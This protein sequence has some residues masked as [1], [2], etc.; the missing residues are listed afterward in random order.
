M[1]DCSKRPLIKILS[2]KIC[3]EGTL[4]FADFM[5]I[6]LYNKEHGYYG[7]DRV[8]IG[9]Q[10]DF[11]TNVSVGK[12]YG[13]TLTYCFKELWVKMEKP[14]KF[15]IVEQGAHN[16]RLADDILQTLATKELSDFKSCVEYLIIEPLPTQRAL[17][18]NYLKNFSNISWIEH[19]EHLPFFEGV[20]F[21]N[22]LLDAFPV[23]ILTWDGLTWLEK[24]V[25]LVDEKFSWINEPITDPALLKA[26]SSLPK[27]LSKNF[28]LE[29]SLGTQPWLKSIAKK[30]SRGAILI[31][32]YGT[33]GIE[34]FSPHRR[35]GTIAC[36]KNHRRFD[37]PLE[38][39]GERDITAQVDF[40]KATE[41]ALEASFEILGYSDQHHFLIGAAEKWL[42]SLEKT[43][44]APLSPHDLR[45]LQTLLHPE[46]MGR[47]FKFLGLGKNIP[48]TPPLEGFQYQRPGVAG[49]EIIL[50]KSM[51]VNEIL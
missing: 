13:K 10:G 40:T 16:G 5:Q 27:N 44:Q 22:E 38:E 20:H 42:R 21:S 7:S 2:E 50:K 36:Y 17:Q 31:A 6:A 15:F 48:A 51:D 28:E 8:K 34:R 29:I 18:Q 14:D 12:I 46:S 41:A 43:D 49:L 24:R 39:P 23:N 25:T 3:R 11:F 33:A 4:S 30:M 47:Q 35:D 19:E 32:D 45:A 1:Q 9:K 26:T 37:N